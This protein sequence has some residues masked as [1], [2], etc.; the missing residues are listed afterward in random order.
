MH[1][2]VSPGDFSACDSLRNAG[3]RDINMYSFVDKIHGLF[4]CLFSVFIH[5]ALRM[6]LLSFIYS[7]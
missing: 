4:V 3:V 2:K 6:R 5:Q 7:Y 1:L